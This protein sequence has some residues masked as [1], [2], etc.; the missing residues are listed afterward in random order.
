VVAEH[1][2]DHVPGDDE[3]VVADGWGAEVTPDDA[4]RDGIVAAGD[5][6]RGGTVVG[7]NVEGGEPAGTSP[8]DRTSG[9][10]ELG[11]DDCSRIRAFC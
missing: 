2:V 10:G 1:A 7:A 6:A 4:V 8:V 11:S 9:G 5:T 3:A